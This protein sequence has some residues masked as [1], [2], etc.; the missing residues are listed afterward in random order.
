M[1]ENANTPAATEKAKEQQRVAAGDQPAEAPKPRRRPAP[2]EETSTKQYRLKP[3]VGPHYDNGEKL[4]PGDV[5]EL[6]ARQ[7]AAFSDKFEA[8]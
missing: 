2:V 7:F 4:E 3:D 1:A 8:V 6:T 5:V